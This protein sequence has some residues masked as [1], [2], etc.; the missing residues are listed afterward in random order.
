MTTIKYFS[1]IFTDFLRKIKLIQNF[2]ITLAISKNEFTSQLNKITEESEFRLFEH[3]I[4]ND[5]KFIGKI[6]D[7][8][9]KISPK[10]RFF[11]FSLSYLSN[12]NGHFVSKDNSVLLNG[13]IRTLNSKFIFISSFIILIFYSYFIVSA[14]FNMEFLAALFLLFHCS[15]LF[16][17]SYFFLRNSVTKCKYI[18]EEEL[19]NITK[20]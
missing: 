7:G 2:A 17:I 16:G 8:C 6:S 15:I 11:D 20:E 5:K 1:L 4:T 19:N 18:L 9:L 10:K 13:E 14:L 12:Y 3:F